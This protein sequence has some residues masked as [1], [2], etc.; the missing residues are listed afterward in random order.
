MGHVHSASGCPCCEDMGVSFKFKP[1]IAQPATHQAQDRIS[2]AGL[3]HLYDD[4]VE[5]TV[6]P[7][8]TSVQQPPAEFA[9][10]SQLVF[11]QAQTLLEQSGRLEAATYRIGYLEA[12]LLQKD[13]E[14][15]LLTDGR[16][17]G[18]LGSFTRWFLRAG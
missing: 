4:P 6:E 1:E 2:T 7:E 5:V 10:L 16:R 9:A 13:E 12:Q 3:D 14:L 11:Q 17:G 8:V 15:K 18:W